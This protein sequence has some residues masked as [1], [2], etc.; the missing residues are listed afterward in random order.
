MPGAILIP[1]GRGVF[2]KEFFP[3]FLIAEGTFPRRFAGA[4]EL[5]HALPDTF[6]IFLSDI[7]VWDG[8]KNARCNLT[9]RED[10]QF[11]CRCQ[12]SCFFV[13]R[14]H[15]HDGIGQILPD[16]FPLPQT[17]YFVQRVPIIPHGNRKKDPHRFHVELAAKVDDLPQ[18][19]VLNDLS[20]S[21]GGYAGRHPLAPQFL[22]PFHRPFKTAPV[23]PK[24]IV[25]FGAGAV[26]RYRAPTEGEMGS[27]LGK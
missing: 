22:K 23:P 9:G 3:E 21:I 27:G 11:A 26:D 17:Q 5:A 16:H 8:D 12:A 18:L 19:P 13:G 4:I 15:C 24:F 10:V 7:A 14:F 20:G 25:S 1:S 2:R 6:Q